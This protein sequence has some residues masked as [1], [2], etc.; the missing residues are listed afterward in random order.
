MLRH[1]AM[2]ELSGGVRALSTLGSFTWGSVRPRR[3]AANTRRR[4]ARGRSGIT[5][6]LTV[7]STARVRLSRMQATGWI[8]VS[9]EKLRPSQSRAQG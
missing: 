5:T 8:A 7:T 3:K 1:G 6:A 4:R 2:A 9:L